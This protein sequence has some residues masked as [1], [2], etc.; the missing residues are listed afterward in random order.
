MIDGTA[1]EF[2]AFSFLLG[3]LHAHVMATPFAL[4]VV[5][6]ALQLARRA[7]DPRPRRRWARVADRRRRAG[8]RCACLGSL[9][10]I[11]SLDFP[12]AALIARPA[13]VLRG[14][15]PAAGAPAPLGGALVGCLARGSVLLF[16][17]FYLSYDP[18][19][20]GIGVVGKHDQFSRLVWDLLLIYALSLWVAALAFSSR[21][22]CPRAS[23]SGGSLRRS[24]F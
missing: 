5:A 10:A 12:T 13:L 4:V 23:S 1:N 16:V 7:E 20:R 15:P 3:D 17:P 22:R 8:A 9:Y 18:A 24:S 14:H 19:A 6:F 21:L 2:P 11:N